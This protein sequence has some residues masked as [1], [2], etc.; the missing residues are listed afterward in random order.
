VS[1]VASGRKLALLV[2]T[3]ALAWSTVGCG[4]GGSSGEQAQQGPHLRDPIN[5]ADCRDWNAGTLDE[6]LGTI[7]GIRDFLGGPVPGTS[8]HGATLS[9]EQA[10][11]LFEGWCGNE[12]ARGFKLYKLYARAAAFVGR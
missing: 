9:D 2:S 10:Y 5:L 1:I 6:R 12:Y 3:L 4:D 8:G 11:K 7:R